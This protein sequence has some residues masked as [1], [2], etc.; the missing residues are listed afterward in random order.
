MDANLVNAAGQ[1]VLGISTGYQLVALITVLGFVVFGIWVWKS[2][3]ESKKV[4][5]ANKRTEEAKTEQRKLSRDAE[6]A[7]L[8]KKIDDHIDDHKEFQSDI[9]EIKQDVRNLDKS[10]TE[11]NAAL[12]YGGF[13]ND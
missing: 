4:I 2:M 10:L 5:E 3:G 8:N 6:I 9:K 1:T 13:K 12:K 7:A 11:L